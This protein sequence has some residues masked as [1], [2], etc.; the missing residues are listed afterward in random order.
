MN[1]EILFRGKRLDDNEWIYGSL[2]E[3]DDNYNEPLSRRKITK[4]IKICNYV[5]GDWSLGGWSFD[6]VIPETV[7]QFSGLLDK[8]GKKIFEEDIIELE[9]YLHNKIK[10]VCKFGTARRVLYENECDITGFYFEYEGHLKTFPIVNNY[11]NKHDLELFEVVGNIYDNS[12]LL[13]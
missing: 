7:G 12:E 8:N 9:N 4:S 5:P 13:I 2:V 6:K 10:V 3:T 1:R 11:A